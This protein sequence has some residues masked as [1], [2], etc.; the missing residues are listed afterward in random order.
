[1]RTFRISIEGGIDAV[2]DLS[3]SD[4]KHVAYME[5]L[6]VRSGMAI[7]YR[8]PSVDPNVDVP[9]G[10]TQ[11]FSY[12][13]RK[14]FSA[15]RRDY[16]AEFLFGTERIY[17]TEYGGLSRKMIDGAIVPLGLNRPAYAPT[18]ESGA[19]VAP[20]NISITIEVGTGSLHKGSYASFRLAYA[21]GGGVL[22][23]SGSI[24][25]QIT[26]DQSKVVLQW[27]NPV[28]DE[29]A[30]EILLFLGSAAGS[31]R[32]LTSLA[33]TET[34]FEYSNERTASG[35]MATDYDQEA[36]LQYCT[37]FVRNVNGVS[38]ESGPSTLS[39][40]IKASASRR[41]IVNPWTDG[42]LDSE[43]LVTWNAAFGVRFLF[44]RASALPGSG[45]TDP[46]SVSS[47]VEDAETGRVLVTFAGT[48]YFCDGERVMFDGIPDDPFSGQTVEVQV[49]AGMTGTCYLSVGEWF[50]PP[51]TLT[52]T[53]AYRTLSVEIESM[54]YNPESG[55]IEIVTTDPHTLSSGEYPTF[56]GFSD[57]SW[58]DENIG[59]V[60]DPA[61]STRLFVRG[62]SMPDDTD[63]SGHFIRRDVTALFY[64][65]SGD[66][67]LSGSTAA[68]GLPGIGDMLYVDMAT[69]GGETGVGITVDASARTFTRASGSWLDTDIA[70]GSSVAFSGSG[71]IGN[72]GPFVVTDVSA[73]TVTCGLAA[74]LVN[75]TTSLGW[76]VTTD[77]HEVIKVIGRND[78][79]IMLASL[80]KNPI[81][82]LPALPLPSPYTD[83]IKFVPH[84]DYIIRRN[85]YRVGGTSEVRLVDELRLEDVE[86]LDAVPDSRLQ[87]IL[88][89]LFE[90]DGVSVVVEPPPFGMDGLIQH[91]NMLFAHE[92]GNNRLRWTL[93]G[94]FDAWPADFYHDYDNMILGKISFDHALIVACEDGLHRVDGTGPTR[95]VFHKSKSAGCRAGRSL[96][97]VG[98]RVIFL[99]DRGLEAF[100]GQESQP[101]TELVIPGEFWHGTSKYV[102]TAAPGGYIVPFL[103]NAAF[104]RLRGPDL[105]GV[106]P[107]S[108]MPFASR[109]GNQRGIRSFLK[110]G[111]YFLY[112][113]GDDANYAAQTMI[114]VDFGTRSR[115][116]SVIGLKAVDAFADELGEV[117]L[118]LSSP[119][120]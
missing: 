31:E 44:V 30:S 60:T 110:D 49:E 38:D 3:L 28:L 95:L 118:L 116:V 61:D 37:T 70:P 27:E 90:Q 13:G 91:Q 26:E 101:L 108:L 41:I 65:I 119:D 51:G 39:P 34:R 109:R 48:H 21:T 112:W 47:I 68:T 17:W 85:L 46:I 113:G 99:G 52:A 73:P 104:E 93:A 1:M 76:L 77:I 107:R 66:P 84:N 11:V 115:A 82:N 89:T 83:G 14:I 20:A 5:N 58:D 79:A 64:E 86:Y 53:T 18:V 117:H 56:T 55:V 97:V 96:Q 105:P 7:P 54:A 106:T 35:E 25:A 42:I 24:Q 72:A 50:T 6:D 120:V 111:K 102:G 78:R 88:P 29:P 2:S 67:G 23:A 63:F 12:R 36:Y 32:Y 114:C 87:G 4:G 43:S 74:T 22:P 94:N 40:Q 57:Q 98:N 80:V 69:T 33:A 81:Y 16:A 15:A 9:T 62:M 45:A 71:H 8:M 59:V 103:Q 10:T 100:D 92:S 75:E 19:A